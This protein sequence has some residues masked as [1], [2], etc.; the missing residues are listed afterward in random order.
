MLFCCYEIRLLIANH[1]IVNLVILAVLA[2][3]CAI[4]D[5]I[6]ERRYFRLNAPWLFLDDQPGNNPQID[7]LVTWAFALLT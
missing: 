4:A 7:G 3:V 2:I 6:L 1:S 5:S